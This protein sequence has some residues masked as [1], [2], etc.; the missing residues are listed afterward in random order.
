MFKRYLFFGILEPEDTAF[1]DDPISYAHS[2]HAGIFTF[3]MGKPVVISK[4]ECLLR[5][6][7]NEFDN[8]PANSLLWLRDLTTG[9]EER[10]FTYQDNQI[11]FW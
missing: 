10:I 6:D 3:D 11:R 2:N 5:N 7:G 8:I 4:I 9:R 1:D